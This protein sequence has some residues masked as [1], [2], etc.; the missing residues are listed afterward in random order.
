MKMC[1]ETT[2]ELGASHMVGLLYST[3]GRT[4]KSL[5]DERYAQWAAEGLKEVAIYARNRSSRSG[6]K[7]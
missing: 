5:P 3:V 6:L 2:A 1:I 4:L 7:R